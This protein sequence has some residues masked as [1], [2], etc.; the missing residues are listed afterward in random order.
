MGDGVGIK[1]D[2]LKEL[3][4]SLGV[5]CVRVVFVSSYPP[6]HCGIAEY[7]RM[8]IAS[9]KSISRDVEVYVI[10]DTGS[11]NKPW[12]DSFAGAYVYPVFAR[13]GSKLHGVLD[14][15]SEIGGADILH[16]QHDYSLYG[17]G[18]QILRLTVRA[19]EEGLA[20]KI[21]FTIHTVHHPY[22]DEKE[23]IEFQRKLNTCDVIIV[24]SHLQ[25]FE[26]RNQGIIPY[27]IE[28]IPHGTLLNPYLGYPRRRL[29]E[30]LGLSEEKIHGPIT[31]IPGFLKRDKGLDILLESLRILRMGKKD[32]T[33]IVAG[34]VWDKRVL[35]YLEGIDRLVNFIFWERYLDSNEILELNA[36]A[37]IVLLP[38]RSVKFYSVSGMLH[39]SMGS[40]K[41]IIGTRVPKLI[42]LYQHAPKLTVSPDNPQALAR[43][44]RWV[45]K[46]YDIVVPY[47]SFLYS[48]AVR[49]QWHRMAQRHLNLYMRLLKKKVKVKSITP[50]RTLTPTE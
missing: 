17:Y 28:R 26:L 16:V 32:L 34:E 27:R 13:G 22:T 30:D 39:L 42:E 15:L 21:V 11:G 31:V 9:L 1:L 50:P 5:L 14:V 29:L 48:Y 37:D 36:L 44:L 2:I 40:L 4:L 33:V 3:Y 8:L 18:D 43:I 24:H 25:E 41:P 49:T 47:M 6:T 46:N 23:T 7:T 20:K 19:R 10:A 35:E 38:Y 12:H 45:V